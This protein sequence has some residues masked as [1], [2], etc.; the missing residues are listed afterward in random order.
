MPQ[1]AYKEVPLNSL[2]LDLENPRLPRDVDFAFEPEVKLLKEFSRRYNLLELARSI[3]DKGFTPRHAE[4]L[5]VV[6][7]TS[8][9]NCYVVIEGNRRLAT[10]KLL[11]N[12][13]SRRE[14]GITGPE[15]EELAEEALEWDLDNL[16]V[17]VYQDRT[18]L[19]DY[20][21]FRHITGP[22]PWRPEAK[23]RFIANLLG[24]GETSR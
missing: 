8:D 3:A 10:V 1:E 6:E 7:D 23:A 15:W 14:A 12:P 20:L 21:G 16:P 13:D 19:Q 4:A 11:T 2:R 18:A 9:E 17:I 22:K 24:A 5:L